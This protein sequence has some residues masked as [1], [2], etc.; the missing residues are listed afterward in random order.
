LCDPVGEYDQGIGLSDQQTHLVMNLGHKAVE[1]NAPFAAVWKTIIKSI[2]Q[3]GF[4][5]TD[6]SP[7][8]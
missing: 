4:A 1:M 5:A 8:V 2:H 7:E 6:P 3:K